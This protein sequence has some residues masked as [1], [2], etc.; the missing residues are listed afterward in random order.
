MH[1]EALQLHLEDI[2]LVMT[3]VFLYITVFQLHCSVKNILVTVLYAAIFLWWTST[4]SM[5]AISGGLLALFAAF[6]TNVFV[7]DL[8][9]LKLKKYGVFYTLVSLCVVFFVGF[10]S[11]AT[12]WVAVVI[13]SA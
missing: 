5:V 10:W 4:T 7:A 6:A 12:P 3:Q 2:H 1:E 8:T 13:G 9:K 11:Y